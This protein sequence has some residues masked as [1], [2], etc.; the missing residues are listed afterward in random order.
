MRPLLLVSVFIIYFSLWSFANW[1]ALKE[2]WWYSD[3]IYLIDRIIHGSHLTC[4]DCNLGRPIAGLWHLTFDI[5]TPPDHEI[6]NMILRF[7]QG[8][9]HSLTALI[10]SIV[11][12]K[13]TFKWTAFLLV[14]PFLLWPFNGEAT[15]WRATGAY[16][17]ATLFG[18]IGLYMISQTKDRLIL[19]QCLGVLC[20]ILAMLSN[21]LAAFAGLVV[22][23]I[24]LSL[25]AL[26]NTKLSFKELKISGLLI[27]GYFLGGISSYIIAVPF[28][29]TEARFSLTSQFTEKIHYLL[30]LNK[31][32]IISENNYYPLWIVGVHVFLLIATVLILAIKAARKQFSFRQYI[33]S[34]SFFSLLFITPYSPLMIVSENYPPWRVLYIAPFLMTGALVLLDYVIGDQNFG[35][36]IVI[37]FACLL[38]IGYAQISW[39]FSK[40]YPELFE[41]DLK[42]LKRI[43]NLSNRKVINSKKLVVATLP[44][45]IRNWNPYN[46]RYH[47]ADSK[48]SAFLPEW[49]APRFIKMFSTLETVEND[50]SFKKECQ[51]VC[52]RN[53][54]EKPFSIH[55]L[56][57]KQTMCL[58]P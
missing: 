44:E 57:D 25:I 20:I 41:S 15:L 18:V 54:D 38:T 22:W 49:S 14:F 4:L 11:I 16:P 6:Y 19:M 21:Q 9:I 51:Q 58:C 29:P 33:L 36:F 30:Y 7:V 24:I 43:E 10:A 45:F 47:H 50:K 23:I 39:S 2:A 40:E 56:K 53:V 35:R 1:P 28:H 27:L 12:W 37:G 5:D 13:T 8:A 34:M 52:Q 42:V 48:T 55:V 17:I 31:L 32:F 46:F 26:K 3:D